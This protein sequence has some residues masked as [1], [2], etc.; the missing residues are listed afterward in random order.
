MKDSVPWPHISSGKFSMKSLYSRLIQ[1]RRISIMVCDGLA[2]LLR[3]RFFCGK[4]FGRSC[5]LVIRLLKGMVM[6]TCLVLF[7]ERSRNHIIFCSAMCWLNFS[8]VA[9]GR[10]RTSTGTHLVSRICLVWWL[11]YWDNL[12]T[13]FGLPWLPNAGHCGLLEISLPLSM[14]SLTNLL[15]VSL[16]CL[17]SYNNGSGLLELGMLTPLTWW[18]IESV[19]SAR[20]CC[21]LVLRRL[22]SFSRCSALFSFYRVCL[23]RSLCASLTLF[24]CFKCCWCSCFVLNFISCGCVLCHD[25]F[26]YKVG[27]I[28]FS[29]KKSSMIDQAKH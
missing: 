27:H 15:I 22:Q 13:A 10:G 24:L 7:V 12:S 11:L 8:G 17:L 5:R 1:G 23:R 6:W 19:L 29:I 2:S 9:F 4:P 14:F 3:L 21:R 28:V 26:I 18:L 25:G 20:P 16:K